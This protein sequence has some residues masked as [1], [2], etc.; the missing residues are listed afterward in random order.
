[1][2]SNVVPALVRKYMTVDTYLVNSM[3]GDHETRLERMLKDVRVGKPSA[4]QKISQTSKEVHTIDDG[5][6]SAR[7]M[8][9]RI[10]K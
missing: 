1:M 3:L 6:R 4:K 8:L 5:S 10:S 2:A 9:P 7:L